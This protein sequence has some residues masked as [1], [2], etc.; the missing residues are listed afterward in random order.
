M[1][2][3][4][5]LPIQ[6]TFTPTA[7]GPAEALVACCTDGPNPPAGF[8]TVSHVRG[9][10]VT[11][12]IQTV[13]LLDPLS[14]NVS[15]RRPIDRTGTISD[16]RLQADASASTVLSDTG[17]DPAAEM[18][19]SGGKQGLRHRQAVRADYGECSIGETK[20]LLLTITNET[21]IEAS[22]SLWLNTFQAADLSVTANAAVSSSSDSFLPGKL[23]GSRSHAVLPSLTPGKAGSRS[24]NSIPS[25]TLSS[26][27]RGMVS[28]GSHA[29]PRGH[30]GTA[31]IT[32]SPAGLSHK[33]QHAMVLYYS[34]ILVLVHLYKCSPHA[35]SL[36][37]S[38]WTCSSCC[39]R[40]L[41]LWSLL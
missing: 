30:K 14:P 37:V 36:S 3:G 32:A 7:T 21:P 34:C 18:P 20:L 29:S 8:S 39:L 28:K 1:S 31:G 5:Q 35:V 27:I 11:Y 33:S 4:Q 38:V 16:S 2:A 13:P 23:A 15:P 12:N 22:V 26:P 24:Q 19:T 10:S 9:L 6:A 40:R 17:T 25:L 41:L